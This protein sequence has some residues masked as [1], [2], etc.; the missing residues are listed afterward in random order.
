MKHLAIESK[1]H[2]NVLWLTLYNG[3]FKSIR[4]LNRVSSWKRNVTRKVLKWYTMVIYTDWTLPLYSNLVNT[5]IN[6]S[7]IT[8]WAFR[9]ILIV[10][11]CTRVVLTLTEHLLQYY[12]PL[13]FLSIQWYF[14]LYKVLPVIT[15]DLINMAQL[16]KCWNNIGIVQEQCYEPEPFTIVR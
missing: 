10:F 8:M 2:R 14:P 6:R 3:A 1:L 12:K 11:L 7:Y 16:A 5:S 13:F 4:F 9:L 15:T